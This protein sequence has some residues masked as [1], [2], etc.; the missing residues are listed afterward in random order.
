[1]STTWWVGSWRFWTF[2]GQPL[3]MLRLPGR[4][5]VWPRRGASHS[6]IVKLRHARSHLRGMFSSAN[7]SLCDL[8]W[9]KSKSHRLKPVLLKPAPNQ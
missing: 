4:C 9:G 2:R 1:M 5:N 8:I 3:H 6:G 7:F